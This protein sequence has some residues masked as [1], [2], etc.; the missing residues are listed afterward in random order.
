MTLSERAEDALL[1]VADRGATN[2]VAPLGSVR[3][4]LLV[5][6][7]IQHKGPG[8]RTT[9]D[10]TEAGKIVASYIRKLRGVS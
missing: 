5:S 8:T 1:L 10:A 4:E 6:G 9:D 2:V 7:L 3:V